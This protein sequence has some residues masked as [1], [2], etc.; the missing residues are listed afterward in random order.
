MMRKA[1]IVLTF[2]STVL[3]PWPLTAVL[4]VGL[5]SVEP[6]IPL[7]VGVFADT[8]YFSHQGTLPMATVYGALVSAVA[9]FVRSR[10]KTGIMG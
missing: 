10:L 7:A 9:F 2:M 1:M 6:L 4:A 3:F 5:A 8:L